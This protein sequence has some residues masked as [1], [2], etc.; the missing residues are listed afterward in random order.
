M[1]P[2]ARGSDIWS[3]VVVRFGDD[4][5]V[6]DGAMVL[7]TR[8]GAIRD[9]GLQSRRGGERGW[10]MDGTQCGLSRPVASTKKPRRADWGLFKF[11]SVP[12]LVS[13]VSLP[14]KNKGA[15][16]PELSKRKSC[17][18]SAA[19]RVSHHRLFEELN[20]PSNW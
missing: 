20:S 7:K 19:K 12:F 4:Q 1:P 18:W 16:Q 9:G 13:A 14:K 6:D 17:V 10:R 5:A 11:N 2:L 3:D 15:A 8:R